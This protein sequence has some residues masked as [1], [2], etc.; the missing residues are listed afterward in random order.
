MSAYLIV[1][2]KIK[3]PEAYEKYKGL[4]KPLVEKNGGEYLA[5]GGALHVAEADLWSPERL[6]I[7]RFPSMEQARGF[8][9]S[10][11]YA[12]VRAIRQAA[13]DCTLSIVEGL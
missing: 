2:T 12:P 10:E 9:E 7:I 5:R 4:A 6:V 8:L 3:D 11:E 1:D 13:A